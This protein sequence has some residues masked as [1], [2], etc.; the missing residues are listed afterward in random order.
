MTDMTDMTDMTEK[1]NFKNQTLLRLYETVNSSCVANLKFVNHIHA[2]LYPLIQAVIDD[3][4]A[5]NEGQHSSWYPFQS[6]TNHM[7]GQHN[8]QRMTPEESMSFSLW[9]YIYH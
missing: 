3:T 2:V 6:I 4:D 8:F 5:Y 9:M 7:N 1:Y